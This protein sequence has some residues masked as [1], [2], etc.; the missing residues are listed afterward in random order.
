[1]KKNNTIII[2]IIAGIL[3]AS[4][5]LVGGFIIHK[6]VEKQNNINFNTYCEKG[7]IVQKIEDEYLLLMDN[8]HYFSFYS[9]ET[10]SDNTVVT[11]TFD[12]GETDKI[13]DDIIIA[14]SV[15]LYEMAE[16]LF[17]E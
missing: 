8:G 16:S 9:D 5:S 17:T 1:M 11:V 4:V 6:A 15:D 10:F 13:E 2:A 14:V 3:I 7:T 12:Y